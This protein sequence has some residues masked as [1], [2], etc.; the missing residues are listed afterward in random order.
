LGHASTQTRCRL[1]QDDAQASLGQVNRG[2]H[3]THTTSDDHN[4]TGNAI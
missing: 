3:T 1:D 4:S 2:A